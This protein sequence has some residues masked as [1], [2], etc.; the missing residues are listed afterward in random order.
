MFLLMVLNGDVRSVVGTI[1]GNKVAGRNY[2]FDGR[3]RS[4]ERPLVAVVVT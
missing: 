1:V 2:R 4:N 3:P